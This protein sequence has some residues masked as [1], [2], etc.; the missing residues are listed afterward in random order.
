MRERMELLGGTLAIESQLGEGS[1]V[2]A[3]IP[4]AATESA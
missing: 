4:C 2:R 3:R 1:V